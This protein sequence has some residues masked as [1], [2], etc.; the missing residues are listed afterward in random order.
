MSA[1]LWFLSRELLIG[2]SLICLLPKVLRDVTG[3]AHY[4][5][6]HGQV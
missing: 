4:Q 6:S 1:H 5:E 2:S 3:Q